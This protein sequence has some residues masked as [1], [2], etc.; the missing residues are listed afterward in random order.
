MLS[1]NM[2]VFVGVYVYFVTGR[3]TNQ[4]TCYLLGEGRMS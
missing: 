1:L 2:H 3:L 4:D